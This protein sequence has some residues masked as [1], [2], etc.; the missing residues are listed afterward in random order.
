MEQPEKR[1]KHCENYVWKGKSEGNSSNPSIKKELLEET[2]KRNR[3]R[4][5]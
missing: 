3:E 5:K 1:I 2:Q 4:D